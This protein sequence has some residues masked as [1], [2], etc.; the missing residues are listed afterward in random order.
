MLCCGCGPL[1]GLDAGCMDIS[2]DIQHSNV[3]DALLYDKGAHDPVDI[4]IPSRRGTRHTERSDLPWPTKPSAM[5]ADQRSIE[6][7]Q[8]LDR[9]SAL[10]P[11]VI[12]PALG[13]DLEARTGT[14]ESLGRKPIACANKSFT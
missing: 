11:L 12:Q 2:K 14:A 7:R 3:C 1:S 4:R 13:R 6:V 10:H 9:V 5:F 8:G